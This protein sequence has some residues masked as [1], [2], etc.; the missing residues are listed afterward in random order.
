MIAVI[1]V[2]PVTIDL[3]LWHGFW[4][5]LKLHEIVKNCFYLLGEGQNRLFPT[6]SNHVKNRV[7]DLG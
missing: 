2:N 3:N 6:I 5:S 4:C 7:T 1:V